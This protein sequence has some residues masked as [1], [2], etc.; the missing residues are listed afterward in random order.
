MTAPVSAGAASVPSWG[1]TFERSRRDRRAR[2][3][4]AGAEAP[5]AVAGRSAEAS[6]D[7]IL[8][9]L[10]ARSDDA[11]AAL[12]DR[13]GATCFGVARRIVVDEH[14]A[15]DVVQ[16]AFLSVW[17][18]AERFDRTRGSVRAWLLTVTHHRAVDLVRREN[19]HRAQRASVELLDVQPADDAHLDEQ[20]AASERADS[21]RRAL[22]AL[23]QPQR[24]A[25]LLAYFGGHTQ[26]EIASLTGTPLGT[27]KTRMLAGMRK[28]RDTLEPT[29]RE[30]A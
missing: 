17:R 11:L 8:A 21:V 12:Y 28:L 23:P 14:L 5:R 25:L 6:D 3:G 9:G 18:E 1:V 13:Y 4:R 29:V 15:A 16:D 27:V 10:R 2:R 26:N 24:E 22:D 20:V 19:R 7:V 30:E